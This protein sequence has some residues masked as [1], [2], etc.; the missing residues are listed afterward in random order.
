MDGKSRHDARVWWWEGGTLHLHV[1]TLEEARRQGHF[2]LC[3]SS[4][5]TGMGMWKERVRCGVLRATRGRNAEAVGGAF[6][7]QDVPQPTGPSTKS[8]PSARF[9]GQTNA[10]T[11]TFFVPLPVKPRLLFAD[12]RGL[13]R[14]NFGQPED[15]ATPTR[16]PPAQSVGRRTDT[17]RGPHDHRTG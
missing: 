11:P 14:F 3:S 17:Q 12:T 15:R 8:T 7:V 1:G 9:G 4:L 6:Q 5:Q 13:N 2:R 10:D 16:E